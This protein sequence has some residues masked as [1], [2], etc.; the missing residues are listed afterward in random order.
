MSPQCAETHVL[1][2]I[3]QENTLFGD[4][5]SSLLVITSSQI[6]LYVVA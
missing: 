4:H 6:S 3:H 1:T 5:F 2:G